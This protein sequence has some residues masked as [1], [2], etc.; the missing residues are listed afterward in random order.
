MSPPHQ[1]Q[2]YEVPEGVK[3]I[4]DSAFSSGVDTVVL[5]DSIENVGYMNV[6][7]IQ[8]KDTNEWF[9]SSDGVLFSKGDTELV[10]YPAGRTE[11]EYTVPE[12]VT[13]IGT[14]AFIRCDS[15][16]KINMPHTLEFVSHQAIGDCFNLE[17]VV[18]ETILE[19]EIAVN[20]SIVDF[21]VP[22]KIKIIFIE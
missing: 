16:V 17:E 21:E 8:V 7:N 20:D 13:A 1:G 10:A 4:S 2:V 22:P 18:F 11:T 6:K 3:E 5:P 14:G 19:F 12:G 15:L 9:F